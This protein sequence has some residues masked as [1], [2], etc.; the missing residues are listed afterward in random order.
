MS[1]YYKEGAPLAVFY[2]LSDA[3]GT[4]RPVTPGYVVETSV[5]QKAISD[6]ANGADVADTLDGAVD[7][8]DT[9]IDRNQGY[10]H[11]G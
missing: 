9:D 7:E 5:F 6:M 11:D 2:G 1:E 3:Q 10:G 8:I 4:L